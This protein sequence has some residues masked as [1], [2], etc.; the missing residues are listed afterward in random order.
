MP[1]VGI[2]LFAEQPNNVQQAV[3][4]GYAVLVSV[5]DKQFATA[6]PSAI[7][8]AGPSFLCCSQRHPMC[9]CTLMSQ[10]RQQQRHSIQGILWTQVMSKPRYAEAVQVV[11]NIMRAR[12]STPAQTAAGKYPFC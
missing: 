7:K 9:Q 11:S 8:E 2:P 1:I 5:F 3:D 10:P 4:G 12:R 6:L